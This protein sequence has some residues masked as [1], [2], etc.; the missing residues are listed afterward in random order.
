VFDDFELLFLANTNSAENSSGMIRAPG[1]SCEQWNLFDGSVS[2]FPAVGDGN[3]IKM[4]FDI[5]PGGS[6]MLCIRQTETSAKS[7][8]EYEWKSAASSGATTIRRV[9][10]N[11]LTLD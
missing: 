11:F 2:A 7:V 4:A 8:P 3:N 5:A 9:Q 6:L 1:K 10:D